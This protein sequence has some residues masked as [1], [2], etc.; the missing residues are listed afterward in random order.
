MCSGYYCWSFCS[1]FQCDFLIMLVIVLVI[2]I[3]CWRKPAPNA[4]NALS[5]H[6]IDIHHCRPRPSN[7]TKKLPNVKRP[8]LFVDKSYGEDWCYLLYKQVWCEQCQV[9]RYTWTNVWHITT[10]LLLNQLFSC[11]EPRRE[12]PTHLHCRHSERVMCTYFGILWNNQQ[13]QLYAVNF[14]P[15][16]GSLYMFRVFYTPIIRSTIFNCIYSHWYKP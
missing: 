14:I 11:I 12:E 8:L 5:S 1:T 13:M 10:C 3:C 2:Q 16:L 4:A 7:K 9:I 6:H 15:L